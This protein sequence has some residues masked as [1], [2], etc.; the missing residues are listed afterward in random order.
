MS[1][2]IKRVATSKVSVSLPNE[3]LPKLD[4]IGRT[5]FKSRSAL[6]RDALVQIYMQGQSCQK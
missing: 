5:T 3:M 1:R 6:I 4:E 2:K